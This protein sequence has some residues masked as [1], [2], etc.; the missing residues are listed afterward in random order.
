MNV[1]A[2][3]RLLVAAYAIA[4]SAGAAAADAQTT[5]GVSVNAT[6]LTG[7]GLSVGMPLGHDF[8]V[9]VAGNAFSRTHDVN[10][11]GADY[12][13]KVKLFTVGVLADWQPFSGAFRLTA[14]LVDN[15]NKITL[16]GKATSGSN[17]TVGDC[18]YTSDPT[19]PLALHGQTNF[20]RLAPYAG[21]GWGGNMN[22]APGFYGTFDLG[23]IFSGAAKIG[24]AASGSATNADPAGHP[25]CGA[26]TVQVASD[27]NFQAQLAKSQQDLND[28]ADNYKLWPAI[29]FGLGWRF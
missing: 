25:Q 5:V 6:I 26:G 15:G 20:R 22:S 10:E 24:L 3:F 29:G 1:R 8:N 18:Q 23:V 7:L 9:R 14:G 21:M 28:K 19:D 12:V 13:G 27:P 11:S 2:S 16:D 17:Y 4:G